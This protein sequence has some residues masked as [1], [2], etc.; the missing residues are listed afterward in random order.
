MAN[1]HTGASFESFLDEQGELE[2]VDAIAIKRVVAWELSQAMERI[3]ISKKEMAARL[4]TSR[5]Q[6]DRLL[7]P[8]NTQVQLDTLV[9]AARAA[10]F[11]LAVTVEPLRD[12]EKVPA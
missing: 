12:A 3:P 2:Q 10:G 1:K 8:H 7:D 6:L 5:S 11:R 9:R 4:H